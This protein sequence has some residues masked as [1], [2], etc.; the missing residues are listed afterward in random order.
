MRSLVERKWAV[1]ID[2]SLLQLIKTRKE[3]RVKSLKM[4]L[5]LCE[6]FFRKGTNSSMAFASLGLVLDQCKHKS[7]GVLI[8]TYTRAYSMVSRVIILQTRSQIHKHTRTRSLFISRL[9][10]ALEYNHGQISNRLSNN[11]TA[12]SP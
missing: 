11:Y 10:N 12:E 1:G 8:I 9:I 3:D 6:D 5:A 2:F 4:R 7:H